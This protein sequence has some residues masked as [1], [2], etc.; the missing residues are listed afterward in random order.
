MNL[1]FGKISKK[2]DTQ[3]IEKGYYIAPR[4]SSWFGDIEIGDYVYLIGGDKIQL[5]RAKEWGTKDNQECLYFGILNND[6]G[7]T[8][9]QFIVLKIFKITRSLAVLTSRSARNKAFF[10]LDLK[11]EVTIEELINSDFYKNPELYRKIRIVVPQDLVAV[12]KDIQ[13]TYENN[14]L[15]LVD[16]D[17]IE[18]NIK[19]DFVD[20]LAKKGG[21]ARMK[22]N[23]LDFFSEKIKSLPVLIT[24]NDVGFRSF[25]D[26]FFCEYRS[27]EKYFL[28]GA[29]WKG[30]DPEDL[31][32]TF[33]KEGI[34][35]NGFEDQLLEEVKAVPIG[36]NVA[37]KAAYVREKKIAVMMIKARGVVKSNAQDGRLLEVEWE[38]D[39]V[40]FEVP[41]G[42]YIRDTIKEVTNK[43]HINAIWFDKQ[44]S[45]EHPLNMSNDTKF[46]NLKF[47]LNQIFYGAPGTGKTYTTKK[48]AVEIIDDI[49]FG[50][51]ADR[52]YILERYNELVSSGQIVFTT[53]HQSISYEDFI[54]GI[55]PET[56]D[57]TVVY[58]IK[59]GIFKHL[60]VLASKE[61]LKTSQQE[62]AQKQL[63]LFEDVWNKLI[64]DAQEKWNNEENLSINTITNKTFEVIAITNQGNLILKPVVEGGLDYT[65]SFTRAKKLYEAFPSLEGIRNINQEFRA[66]IGGMNAT[67]YWSVLNYL[68]NNTSEIAEIKSVNEQPKKYVLIIDEINRGNISSIFGELI[69]LIEEDK[70]KSVLQEREETIEVELPYSNDKF[71]VP[72]N[73]YII[74]TMNTA[75]RSVEALDTALRRRFS[76]VEMQADFDT[77]RKYHID[78]SQAVILDGEIDLAS[79]LQVINDR[80]ELLIDKDHQIGHS[81]FIKTSTLEELKRV[82]SDKIIPLLEE[83]FYGD[84]G[85]IGLILG[86]GF[87]TKKYAGT[88]K[89][90]FAKF[91]YGEEGDYTSF[92]DKVIY[93]FVNPVNWTAATF[94]SIYA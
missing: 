61:V 36:S 91:S 50:N 75:D 8:V 4:G 10:K 46:Y 6:L 64:E 18:D 84:Y 92:S 65:V 20:N 55:K 48:A 47:P 70:R 41:I 49:K 85:K 19:N 29:F 37:I 2:F 86:E 79:M 34:W 81:F 67:A 26:A 35:K 62:T 76:F 52:S 83:Y 54:E 88:Q 5:W 87:I 7:V 24:Y 13:L 69:T 43:Q 60:S 53:F 23:I 73:L 21:G 3:Q 51:D 30:N 45:S 74:G 14:K 68:K 71:S 1:F 80:I 33:I 39:F 89:P 22:D 57:N 93:D 31:T 77:L 72:D 11:E 56:T 59:D 28:V 12:S 17:F 90:K 32:G 58:E 25:Y 9:S 15:Q 16:N 82:F 42:S 66:V 27:N 40:P 78:N 38:E 44:N 94:K 63:A